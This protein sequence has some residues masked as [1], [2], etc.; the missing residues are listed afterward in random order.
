MQIERAKALLNETPNTSDPR[1]LMIEVLAASIELVSLEDNDFMWSSWEDAATAV[2]E[3]ESY[4][5]LLESSRPVNI[6]RMSVLFAPTGPMQELSLSSGWGEPF[7]KLASYFDQ[8]AE[9]MRQ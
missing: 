5:R 2:Q 7:I 3:L 4:L 1:A 9:G 6:E 8:A